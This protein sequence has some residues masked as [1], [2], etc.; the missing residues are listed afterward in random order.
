MKLIGHHDALHT[1]TDVLLPPVKEVVCGEPVVDGVGGEASDGK[2]GG[3]ADVATPPGLI[4]PVI[5]PGVAGHY[6]EYWLLKR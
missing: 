6:L 5:Q 3:V 1:E 4:L 2:E